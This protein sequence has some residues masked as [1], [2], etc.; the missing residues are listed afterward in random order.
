VKYKLLLFTNI[1]V[2]FLVFR[3]TAVSFLMLALAI[4]LALTKSAMFLSVTIA[5]KNHF[6]FSIL[7]Y[8]IK[9]YMEPLPSTWVSE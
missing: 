4:T 2:L 1:Q 7:I 8:P 5:L 9:F 6:W 3:M